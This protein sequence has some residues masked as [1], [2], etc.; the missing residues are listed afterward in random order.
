MKKQYKLGVI[1]CGF[2]GETILKGAV[3][4]DFLRGKKIIV[5]DI[6][7]ENLDKADELGVHVTSDNKFVAENSEFLLLAVKPSDFAGVVDSLYGYRPDKVISVMLGV[8]KNT[9]KNALGVGLIKVA[10][11][12]LNLPCTIGSGA[13]GLDMTDFNKSNDDTDFIYSLFAQLG[14]IVSVDESKVDAV[15]ALS[16]NGP[17]SVIMFID[18]LIEAGVRQGLPR[19][20]AKILAVQTVLG[21]AE[22]VQREEN[23][24][25]E[26]LS[27]A[28]RGG[29]G[30]EAVKTL[31]ERGLR[32]IVCD[33]VE[34]CASR[35]KELSD[36]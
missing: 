20:E 31:E 24:V 9:I 34:A 17:A 11:C 16:V 6:A 7:E 26:L 27:L 23:T 21:S 14:T 33:T 28:C 35:A 5:S 2:I 19:S 1:G 25:S 13:I 10:R 29:T 8:K 30:I 22:M 32:Q 15:T 12:A 3:L 36:K 4:S 18:S